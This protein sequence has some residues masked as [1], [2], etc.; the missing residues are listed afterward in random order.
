MRRLTLA[1]IIAITPFVWA[2]SDELEICSATLSGLNLDTSINRLVERYW[3]DPDIELL[4]SK[5][6]NVENI[7]IPKEPFRF[8]A[9]VSE[10]DG[11]LRLI[12]TSLTSPQFVYSAFGFHVALLNRRSKH[13]DPTLPKVIAGVIRGTLERKE[14]NPELHTLEILAPSLMNKSL[15]RILKQ[16]GFEN[17]NATVGFSETG[18]VVIGDHEFL[19]LSI[20]LNSLN[21]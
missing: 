5:I 1:L 3:D 20:D 4:T 16:V 21:H 17:G 2:E 8:S 19:Q 12:V 9:K 6:K 15:I 14:V 18:Q 10:S 7:S 11:R 13:F